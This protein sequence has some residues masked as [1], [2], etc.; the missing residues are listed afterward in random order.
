TTVFAASETLEVPDLHMAV[1]I[2]NADELAIAVANGEYNVIMKEAIGNIGMTEE[3]YNQY[4]AGNLTALEVAPQI[5]GWQYSLTY[6]TGNFFKRVYD[7]DDLS[8]AEQKAILKSTSNTEST[9]NAVREYRDDYAEQ[10]VSMAENV[11][12]HIDSIIEMNDTTYFKGEMLGTLDGMDIWMS[13][14]FTIKNGVGI[15][16]KFVSFEGPVEPQQE[17]YFKEIVQSATYKDIPSTGVTY[18]QE[19]ADKAAPFIQAAIFTGIFVV[20]MGVVVGL[21]IFLYKKKK[22]KQEE[23]QSASMP[24]ENTQIEGYTQ[25]SGQQELANE[26]QDKSD[27][28]EI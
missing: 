11:T 25:E 17:E 23:A 13:M 18:A 14:Y 15:Y 3:E 28:K 26:E 16:H 22:R 4:L 12:T 19:R 20:I 21:S 2:P 5:G 10:G 7:I 27:E 24:Q 9:D 8:D 6:V 1:T